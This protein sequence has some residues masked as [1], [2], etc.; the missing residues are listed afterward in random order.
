[1]KKFVSFM[2]ALASGKPVADSLSTQGF[3]VSVFDKSHRLV[4]ARS[5][6]VSWRCTDAEAVNQAVKG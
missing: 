2:A 5:T 1:M 3:E 4:E 6:Y